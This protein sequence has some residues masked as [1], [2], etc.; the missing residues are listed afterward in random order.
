M[1]FE[2]K[3]FDKTNKRS[4][5]HE[6]NDDERGGVDRK[7]RR[8]DGHIFLIKG[9]SRI[10]ATT[11]QHKGGALTVA[12]AIESRGIIKDH[13]AVEIHVQQWQLVLYGLDR[14]I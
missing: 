9:H 11:V 1:K 10:K 13:G 2:L 5:N 14:E 8:L 4:T 7:K 12:Q 6:Q 3:Q